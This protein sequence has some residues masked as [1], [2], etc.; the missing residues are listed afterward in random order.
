LEAGSD[1]KRVQHAVSLAL[2]QARLSLEDARRSVLNLRAAPLEGR[3]LA[4]ALEIIVQNASIK[5]DLLIE[6]H[7]TGKER[8]LPARIEE[9]LYRICQEAVSNIVHHAGT[10]H[11]SLHL[12]FLPG[13]VRVTIEDRGRG[14]DPENIPPGHY[15]LVG[16]SERAR[17][18]GGKLC[19]QSSPDEGTR[20]AVSIQLSSAGDETV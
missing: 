13:V 7:L 9:G 2:S 14:F 6:Y 11:A 15:G 18:M 17:L 3:S 19:I 4:Q 12:E 8:L 1:S 10:Q 20:I 5:N 16:I